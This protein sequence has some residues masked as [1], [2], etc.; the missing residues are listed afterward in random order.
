MKGAYGTLSIRLLLNNRIREIGAEQLQQQEKPLMGM[1]ASRLRERSRATQRSSE[2]GP[3]RTAIANPA[4][5]HFWGETYEQDRCDP[6]KH[7]V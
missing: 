4:V 1:F 7:A 3:R 6:K 5:T 2:R